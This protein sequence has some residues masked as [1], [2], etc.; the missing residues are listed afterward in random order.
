[1]NI[2][3]RT[4]RILQQGSTATYKYVSIAI[5]NSQ[6]QL[7]IY[8][9][10]NTSTHIGTND[11]SWVNINSSDGNIRISPVQASGVG[12]DGFSL[13][14]MAN[15]RWLAIRPITQYNQYGIMMGAFEIMKEFGE[16]DTTCSN[17]FMSST[18]KMSWSNSVAGAYGSC[19]LVN[20]PTYVT[21]NATKWSAIST[22]FGVTCY[23]GRRDLG[24]STFFPKGMDN[25]AVTLTAVEMVPNNPMK[26]ALIRGRIMGIKSVYG[27]S[28]WNDGAMI[29]V[30]VDSNYNMVATGAGTVLNHHLVNADQTYNTRF[31]IPA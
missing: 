14:L 26:L 3:G 31:L 25:G 28:V 10:W 1:V 27:S 20:N 15:P 4:Y 22:P 17:I 12:I 13:L 2:V 23:T 21:D 6:I 8:E 7:K 16:A 9:S 29:P 18:Q 5:S 11:G 24:F 19:K 30:E